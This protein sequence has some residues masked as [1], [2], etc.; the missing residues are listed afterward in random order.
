MTVVFNTT[1]CHLL[2]ESCHVLSIRVTR[3]LRKRLHRFSLENLGFSIIICF[4]FFFIASPSGMIDLLNILGS[5]QICA[6][7]EVK[8]NHA[9]N[10][11]LE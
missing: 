4:L 7:K 2:Q 3:L 1:V 10:I 5:A 8:I 6:N 9:Y 11:S